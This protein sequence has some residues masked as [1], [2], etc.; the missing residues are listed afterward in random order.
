M[1]SW[2]KGSKD[3]SVDP[4]PQ[5]QINRLTSLAFWGSQECKTGYSMC[6]HVSIKSLDTPM[7]KAQNSQI[8]H[9]NKKQKVENKG[10]KTSK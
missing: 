8:A 10:F 7:Y 2:F 9:K 1:L 6:A 4:S 3:T 5:I